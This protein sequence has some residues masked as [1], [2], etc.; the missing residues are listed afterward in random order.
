MPVQ[1]TPEQVLDLAPDQA[2]RS[3]ASSL[4]SASNKW[5]RL[6]RAGQVVW[7]ECQGSRADP[8][9][10]QL[11]LDGPAFKCSCPSR[12]VPCK[13]ALALFVLFTSQPGKFETSE[14]PDWVTTWLAKRAEQNEKR[15]AKSDGKAAPP[16]DSAAQVKRAAGRDKK[17][18]AGI[19]DLE[20]WLRDLLRQ[21]LANAQNQP[22][23]FWE[24]TAGRLVDAQAP[25]LARLV[26]DMASICASGTGWQSRLLDQ[27]GRLYLAMEGFRRIDQLPEATQADLR[28][29]AGISHKQEEVLTSGSVLSDN[30]LVLGREIE[31]ETG[32]STQRIWL[33]G[34]QSGW[35]ALLLSFA[36]P[37]STFD[38]SLA[39]GMALPAELVFY[40]GAYPQRAIVRSRQPAQALPP[41][42]PG[43]LRLAEAL[44]GYAAALAAYP[45]LERYPLAANQ[46][47]PCRDGERWLLVDAEQRTIP[48]AKNFLQGWTL[49]AFSG[50]APIGVFGEWNGEYLL[51]LSAWA[52]GQFYPFKPRM[53]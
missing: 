29:L 28:S 7:G 9:R 42:M 34:Q 25:G 15:A 18:R 47:T 26:R 48:L 52:N 39:P 8:Y 44:A 1:W 27:V 38:T 40:P 11:D 41:E 19:D 3:N 14:P 51:P 53:E 35:S 2:S 13:H 22:H 21:G 17:I 50:G 24:N 45:W 4:A 20:P 37:G 23:S 32:L 12:K 31:A 5:R 33:V 46:V 10:C 43:S 30:W 36:T 49:L 16:P 6:Q